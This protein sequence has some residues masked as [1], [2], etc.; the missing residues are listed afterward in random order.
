MIKI[1]VTGSR[2]GFQSEEQ[3]AAVTE[4]LRDN[5]PGELHHGDCVGVDH[6]VAIL[7]KSLGY[8]IVGHPPIKSD[9]RAFFESD[10]NMLPLSYFARDRKIVDYCDILMVIPMQTSPQSK[11]GTWYTHDYAKKIGRPY[12]I[13]YP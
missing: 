3:F 9:L 6:E 11:G 5:L 2:H 10:L 13:F 7:A 4:F 1:G 8:K 12:K